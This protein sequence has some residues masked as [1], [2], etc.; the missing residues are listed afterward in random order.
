LQGKAAWRDHFLGAILQLARQVKPCY[1]RC[2]QRLAV[3]AHVVQQR[4]KGFRPAAHQS[5]VADCEHVLPS[6]EADLP[7]AQSVDKQLRAAALPDH[8]K[9]VPLPV[10]DQR[11]LVE[12]KRVE[13]VAAGHTAQHT[14]VL[15]GQRV[16]AALAA[17]PCL[18]RAVR[19]CPKRP[20]RRRPA[21]L[22]RHALRPNLHKRRGRRE[23]DTRVVD[24][25]A[26][27]RLQDGAV[28][29]RS[30]EVR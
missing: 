13:H 28:L 6:L 30:V 27:R 14:A 25:P 29:Q 20:Q 4:A 17:E 8:G 19:T 24:R 22:E 16:L 7:A 3:H 5:G 15:R 10:A 21:A 1:I 12:S 9:V 18:L 23:R 11:R 26:G 2:R